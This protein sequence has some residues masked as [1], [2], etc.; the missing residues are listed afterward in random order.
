MSSKP[1]PPLGTTSL[2]GVIAD[3]VI[4]PGV[5]NPA[6][7]ILANPS[8]TGDDFTKGILSADGQWIYRMTI[9]D[10][11]WNVN[12]LVPTVMRTAGKILP[13]Q[14]ITSGPTRYKKAFLEMVDEYVEIV[15]G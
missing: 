9:V 7:G 13:E 6:Q 14:T 3:R 11:L 4:P 15:E 1:L 5:K 2:P 8:P 12:K 10:F